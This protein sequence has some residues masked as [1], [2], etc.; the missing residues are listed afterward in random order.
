MIPTLAQQLLPE[1]LRAMRDQFRQ[2]GSFSGLI[3]A[4]LIFGVILGFAYIA[5]E[6]QRRRRSGTT[7]SVTPQRLFDGLLGSL[8][9]SRE[10]QAFLTSACEESKVAHPA[11][12]LV[13]EK[14]FD[15]VVANATQGTFSADQL[16]A[17]RG[18]LF[19]STGGPGVVRSFETARTKSENERP[20]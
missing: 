14:L 13:A 16:A 20:A 2:G 10:E 17:L 18:R 7:R 9:I 8:R 3:L 15:E 12:V 19:P 5:G 4:L 1:P 6:M 11:S